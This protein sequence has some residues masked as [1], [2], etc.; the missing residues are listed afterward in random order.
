MTTANTFWRP[1]TITAVESSVVTPSASAYPYCDSGNRGETPLSYTDPANLPFLSYLLPGDLF[2]S[3]HMAAGF[4]TVIKVGSAYHFIE[5]SLSGAIVRK[6]QKTLSEL[7][8][9]VGDATW[10]PELISATHIIGGTS[11]S[12]KSVAYPAFTAGP[13]VGAGTYVFEPGPDHDPGTFP[14]FSSSYGSSISA[15]WSTYPDAYEAT[16]VNN[17][18][19]QYFGGFGGT[20]SGT[21]TITNPD[22]A[23]LGLQ[24]VA[25]N[26]WAVNVTAPNCL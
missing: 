15:S 17:T 8:T 13:T 2:G 24:C 18:F 1:H 10:L 14:V 12:W 16:I 25:D 4:V 26:L 7:R 11:Q 6:T 22:L 5:S 20:V 3:F 9:I 19:R 21:E 23:P